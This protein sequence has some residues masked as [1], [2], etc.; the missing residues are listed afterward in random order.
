MT[1]AVH[2]WFAS[3]RRGGFRRKEALKLT[4]VHLKWLL[5]RGADSGDD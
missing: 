1:T 3:Y 5:A 4:I 2:E